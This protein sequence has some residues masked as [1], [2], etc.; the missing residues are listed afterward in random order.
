[1]RSGLFSPRLTRPLLKCFSTQPPLKVKPFDQIPGPKPLP[2]IK[3]LW[4]FFPRIG[5]KDIYQLD[6]FGERI[7]S[8]YG[9]LVRFALPGTD[10]VHVFDPK[11]I[12]TVYQV[13]GKLPQRRS[14]LILSHFRNGKPHIYNSGGILTEN[15]Q[16]WWRLRSAYQKPLSRLREVRGFL[17]VADKIILNFLLNAL[18]VGELI[19]D[20]TDLIARLYLELIWQILFGEELGSFADDQMSKESLPW[21]VIEAAETV[22][23]HI[24]TTDISEAVWKVFKTQKYKEVEKSLTF[25]EECSQSGIERVIARQSSSNQKCVISD[26]LSLEGVDRKDLNGMVIDLLLGGVDTTSYTTGFLLYHLGTHP[27]VQKR[28]KDEV[29]LFLPSPDR[30]QVSREAFESQ[31]QYARATLKE[32]FRLNP[33]SVGTSR[34]LPQDTV[35]S[36]YHVPKGTI[37]ILQ[38]MI[39]CRQEKNFNRSMAF[40]PERW[41]KGDTEF[42]KSS[43]FLVLPFSH[44][45]RTC[46]ARRVAEQN[47]LL[48]LIRLSSLYS[49]EWCGGEMGMLTPLINKPSQPLRITLKKWNS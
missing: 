45:V 35:L 6:K 17:P 28:L 26:Y 47:L 5:D 30:S 15:G 41:L 29:G 2:V 18:P 36:G 38:N 48:F 27:Q 37:V 7:L 14:H 31:T 10:I 4:R 11:D 19:E 23:N 12:E 40:L 21:R 24:L 32:A 3:N 16:K 49:V 43:P 42:A 44:G 1:M 8:Q 39:A 9:E 25:L 46:I 22:N 13:E 20:A 34:I 33:I